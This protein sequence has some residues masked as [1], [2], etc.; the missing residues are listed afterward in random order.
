MLFRTDFRQ[1]EAMKRVIDI[2]QNLYTMT[3]CIL[4]GPWCCNTYRP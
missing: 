4:R 3:K 2:K 1:G